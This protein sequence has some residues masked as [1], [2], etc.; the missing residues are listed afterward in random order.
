MKS[1]CL[2]VNTRLLDQAPCYVSWNFR[3]R[4]LINQVSG[5]ISTQN[6]YLTARSTLRKIKI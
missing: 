6:L 1:V 4:K 5:Q 3:L 2:D